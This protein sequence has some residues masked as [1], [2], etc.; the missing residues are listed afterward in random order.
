MTSTATAR[1]RTGPR[2]RN[3]EDG[4]AFRQ[5]SLRLTKSLHL[6]SQQRLDL[7]AEAF[8]LTN[9]VNYDV[10][11]IDG[12]QYLSGPTLANPKLPFVVN[13]FFGKARATLPGREIQLGVRWAF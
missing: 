5:L 7:I 9:T 8:N 12:A 13:P 3:S 1:I 4:P 6:F 10:T 11:S 2:A